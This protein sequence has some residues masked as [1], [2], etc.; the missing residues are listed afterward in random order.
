MPPAPAG[1]ARPKNAIAIT[2]T[3]A[4][5]IPSAMMPNGGKVHL[6]LSNSSVMGMW[7]ASGGGGAGG[8]GTTLRACVGGFG[9][10]SAMQHLKVNAAHDNPRREWYTVQ[11]G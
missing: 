10:C 3:S 7:P 11:I 9:V 6:A 4:I 5:P 8:F 2:A 1:F